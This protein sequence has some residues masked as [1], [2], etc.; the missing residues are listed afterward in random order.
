MWGKRASTWPAFSTYSPI[1]CCEVSTARKNWFSQCSWKDW[2]G[3]AAGHRRTVCSRCLLRD[4]SNLCFADQFT[5]T[6]S[7]MLT[8]RGIFVG[9]VFCQYNWQST[10]AANTCLSQLFLS[11]HRISIFFPNLIKNIPTQLPMGPCWL[12]PSLS[13]AARSNSRFM[14][15][16]GVVFLPFPTSGWTTYILHTKIM[17]LP[18]YPL[19]Q[20]RVFPLGKNI[21]C[22]QDFQFGV[23]RSNLKERWEISC[24]YLDILQGVRLWTE[25]HFIL[26][27]CLRAHTDPSD[28]QEE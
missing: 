3:Q 10:I 25:K 21:Q 2:P 1:Q 16:V 24:I 28:T 4:F 7:L 23:A 13:T 6:A 27:L 19:G 22:A 12:L 14:S 18:S 5:G 8:V 20:S 26:K 17:P 9:K 11:S 15:S